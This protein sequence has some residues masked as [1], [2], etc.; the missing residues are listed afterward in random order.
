MF[1]E[2]PYK[3]GWTMSQIDEMDATFFSV[4]MSDNQPISQEKE[5]YLSDIW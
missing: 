5:V 1:P 4:L 2:N 3:N